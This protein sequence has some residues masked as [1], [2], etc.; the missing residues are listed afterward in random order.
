MGNKFIRIGNFIFNIDDISCVYIDD[1]EDVYYINI[2]LRRDE[3]RYIRYE[4][5]SD[6]DEDFER[7]D[8]ILEAR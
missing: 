1:E 7:I 4:Y 8:R 6:R 3:T 5:Q 2:S